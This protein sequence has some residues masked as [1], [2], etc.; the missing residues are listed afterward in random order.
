[1]NNLI[2]DFVHLRAMRAEKH[3]Q[4]LELLEDPDMRDLVEELGQ[5]LRDNST[6]GPIQVVTAPKNGNGNGSI[7]QGR[8]IPSIRGLYAEIPRSFTNPDLINLLKQHQYDFEGKDEREI[9]RGAV[10][11][12]CKQKNP[13]FRISKPG[14]PGSH[15]E[16]EKVA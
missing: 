4:F 1:M 10:L 2:K 13:I 9:V 12:L 3:S 14:K 11:Y 8:I 6:P 15:N 5:Y 16:Y 7:V